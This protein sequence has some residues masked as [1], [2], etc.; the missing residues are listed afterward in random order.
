MSAANP[1][2][3]PGTA[4]ALA[5][6]PA[7]A[8]LI[9]RL[10]TGDRAAF[11]ELVRLHGPNMLAVIRRIVHHEEESLDALQDALVSAH[12]GLATF[13]GGS[14][15]STW[16]HRVAVNAAL[17]RLRTKRRRPERSIEELLPRFMDDGHQADPAGAWTETAEQVAQQQETRQF[18]RDCIAELPENYRIVLTLRDIEEL[19]TQATAELLGIEPNAVKVRLHRARQALRMLLDKR[20]RA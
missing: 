11:E 15:L 14:R 12:R 4:A 1:R 2:T 7:E 16:L 5:G 17:M 3:T 19:D 6:D 18:V 13:A 20:F 10:T 9:R 8:E